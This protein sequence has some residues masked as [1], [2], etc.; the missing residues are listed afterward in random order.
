MRDGKGGN[1]FQYIKRRCLE[2][3]R[4]MPFFCNVHKYRGQQQRQQEQDVID[5]DPDM[6]DAVLQVIDELPERA[7]FGQYELLLCA[8]RAEN[9]S[10][11][12]SRAFQLEQALVL[13]VEIEQHL[14][15]DVDR[16]DL[17]AAFGAETQ[18]RVGAVG[19]IVDQMLNRITEVLQQ[20]DKKIIKEDSKLAPAWIAS[21]LLSRM[22]KLEKR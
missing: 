4:R 8:I 11:H 9:R 6:P 15:V 12:F 14:V 19:M 22:E 20:E 18:Y 13:R 2:A 1:D 3:I 5:T 16:L 21:I 17:A 10:G 7:G